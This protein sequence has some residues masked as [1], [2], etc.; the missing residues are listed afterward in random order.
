MS[1]TNGNQS[2]GCTAGAFCQH[3]TIICENIDSQL[4]VLL[5]VCRQHL[6]WLI[7]SIQPLLF[8]CRFLSLYSEKK[9]HTDK[10]VKL[11]AV[12]NCCEA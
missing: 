3:G 5:S 4:A 9:V 8:H 6:C 7:D 10:T 11:E 1:D 2:I 12:A